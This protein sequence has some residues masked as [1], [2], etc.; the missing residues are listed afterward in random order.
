MENLIS[1]IN[2][3][4]SLQL[5]SPEKVNKGFLSENHIFQGD[6]KYFLKRYRFDKQDRI[7][8]IHSAKRYFADGGIPV[9]LPIT[10]T[11]GNTLFFFEN[12]YFAL[13][14]FVSDIQLE[15]GYLT[16]TAVISFGEML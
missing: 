10:N 16:D 11:K 2:S 12:G 5:H 13:F 15:R 3:L 9:I 1:E 4:Y 14:P 7:E 8:E 6:N